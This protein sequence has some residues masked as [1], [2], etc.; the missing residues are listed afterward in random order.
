MAAGILFAVVVGVTSAV[1]AGQQHSFEARQRIAASLAAEELIGRI[2]IA[3]YDSLPIW[4]GFSEPAGTMIDGAGNP[5]PRT[6]AAIGRE[7][8]IITKMESISEV[9]VALRG[10]QIIVRSFN[11]NGRILAELGRFVPEPP[12]P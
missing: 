9:D 7:V 8:E 6:F 10:R 11:E 4:N 2:V 12:V 1:T 3:D 5:L